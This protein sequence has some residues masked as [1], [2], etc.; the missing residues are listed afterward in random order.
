M[1]TFTIIIR[2]LWL[3][4][5]RLQGPPFLSQDPGLRLASSHSLI[6]VTVIHLCALPLSSSPP[7]FICVHYRYH[8]HHHHSS[9]CTTVIIFTTIIHLCALPLLS[10]PPSLSLYVLEIVNGCLPLG[11]K[12]WKSDSI[13]R[14]RL[15]PECALAV[16]P[17]CVSACL[18]I[19]VHSG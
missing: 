1:Y 17:P 4:W 13:S 9:V 18:L 15:L 3:C 14:S 10:S 12:K 7:S 16:A 6:E 5:P 2:W 19:C 11:L 8:L